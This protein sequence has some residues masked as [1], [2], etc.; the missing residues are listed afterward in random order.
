LKTRPYKSPKNTSLMSWRL[1]PGDTIG[2]Y[3]NTFSS[4]LL[5]NKLKCSRSHSLL[6]VC[7]R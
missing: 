2:A 3:V 7:R 4:S 1:P 6:V 5:L